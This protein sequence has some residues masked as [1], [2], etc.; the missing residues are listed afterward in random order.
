MSYLRY[1][2]SFIGLTLSCIALTSWFQLSTASADIRK[3]EAL[4][5]EYQTRLLIQSDRAIAPETF[6][7]LGAPGVEAYTVHL[8]ME[9]PI[10]ADI[11]VKR[12]R[13]SGVNQ[14]TYQT[15]RIKLILDRPMYIAGIRQVPPEG[16]GKPHLLALELVAIS[17][18]RFEQAADA[19]RAR[20]Q[21]IAART[22][23]ATLQES[24]G[25][26]PTPIM[27]PVIGAPSP[28][29][30]VPARPNIAAPTGKAE[31]RHVIVI[32][33]GHG[34]KDPGASHHGVIER[35]IVLQSAK[36]LKAILERQTNFD[37]RLT[38]SDDRFIEL[39]D[40]V[41]LARNWG[42]DLFISIHADAAGRSS[43]MGAAVYTLSAKGERRIDNTAR[44]QDWQLP[45][46]T[47]EEPTE[48]V[49]ILED[50]LKR[51][52]KSNSEKFASLLIPELG[53]FGPVL[54]EQ[55]R[56]GNFFVLLAPDVPAVLLE[57]G[58]LTNQKDARRLSSG[59]GQQKAMQAVAN[60]IEAYFWRQELLLS[61]N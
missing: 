16:E 41:T 39:H 53:K 46:E 6:S 59:S 29:E 32:D 2:L 60:A 18:A 49:A 4:G 30:S 52:T 42:A 20:L 21:T 26:T 14:I 12:A 7:S 36:R 8:V 3:I 40:R 45:I 11:S 24:R 17:A 55:K 5:D 1:A 58:F 9:T 56:G 44:R 37:V 38:R 50:F 57:M 13:E 22:R 34:G 43:V 19:D 33:P 10:A 48:V 27:T 61:Q 35:T 15:G 54:S 47:G 31:G 28:R 25:A 23:Y 51:E